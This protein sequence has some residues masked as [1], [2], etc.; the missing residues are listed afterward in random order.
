MD[1]IKYNIPQFL[2]WILFWIVVIIS[3]IY[4]SGLGDKIN[5]IYTYL[6]DN[7]TCID[8]P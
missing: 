6:D 5:S 7:S 8:L 3:V 4:I 2:L 1:N